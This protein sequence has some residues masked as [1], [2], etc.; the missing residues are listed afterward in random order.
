MAGKTAGKRPIYLIYPSDLSDLDLAPIL[1]KC[2]GILKEI[3]YEKGGNTAVCP[4]HL[5][6]QQGG[7][8]V[9][10][11][12]SKAREWEYRTICIYA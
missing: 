10:E 5:L 11:K 12:H 7:C 9:T 3:T 6:N 2:R 4:P 8:S 1:S